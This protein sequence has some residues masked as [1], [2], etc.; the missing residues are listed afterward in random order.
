[1]SRTL[2]QFAAAMQKESTQQGLEKKLK[3]LMAAMALTGES[4]SKRNYG[5]NGLGV[6]TGRLKQSIM[7]RALSSNEGIGLVL[8]AGDRQQVVYAA[9]H[10]FG[11]GYPARPYIAPAIE[12]V[13]KKLP[14]DIRGAF[15]SAVLDR[16]YLP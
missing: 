5:R 13:K 1:M 4:Y 9:Q 6:V 15:R 11:I 2:Q 10:E 14:D 16:P 12:H 7:G 8:T 3:K